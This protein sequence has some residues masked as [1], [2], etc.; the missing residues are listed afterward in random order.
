MLGK[1]I[2][3]DFGTSSIKIYKNGEGVILHQKS[4]IAIYKKNHVFAVGDEAFEMYEKAP[5]NLDVS[6]P[7]KNGVIADIGNMQALIDYFF[8]ELNGKK[9]FKGAEYYIA[10]PTDITEVEKRAYFDLIANTNCDLNFVSC[11]HKFLQR[12]TILFNRRSFD[13]YMALHTDSGADF[14]FFPFIYKIDKGK[15]IL[16][17]KISIIVIVK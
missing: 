8:A 17:F 3:I 15:K 9:R 16:Y 5:E 12:C 13:I 11:R 10:V 14:C 2:G 1:A 7:I 6:Y 4:V